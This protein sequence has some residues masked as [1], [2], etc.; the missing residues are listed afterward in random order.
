MPILSL[1]QDAIH[2]AAVVDF[3]RDHRVAKLVGMNRLKLLI[4]NLP[5][6]K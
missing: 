6:R 3:L 2:I 4:L 1:M 5:K